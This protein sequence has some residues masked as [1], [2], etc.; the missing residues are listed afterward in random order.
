MMGARLLVNNRSVMGAWVLVNNLRV[1]DA[2]FLVN[3]LCVA[4]A[5]FLVNNLGV[6]SWFNLCG[7]VYQLLWRMV[8]SQLL[9]PLISLV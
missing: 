6:M 5:W 7:V 3:H 2:W 1:A 9:N 8:G 4:D